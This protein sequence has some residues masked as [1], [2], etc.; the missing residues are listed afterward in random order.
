MQGNLRFQRLVDKIQ[1]PIQT[2]PMC[3]P[4]F[5]RWFLVCIGLVTA[6]LT[7]AALAGAGGGLAANEVKNALRPYM[8]AMHEC[9][10]RQ[11]E[12]NPS[13]G[14]KLELSFTIGNRGRIAR[15]ELLTEE[16][17]ESYIA[18]C[19]DGVLRSV[20]FPRFKGQP[21]VVPKFPIVLGTGADVPNAMDEDDQEK[22]TP[23][24][25]APRKIR[26]K[27]L[28]RLKTAVAGLRACVR[29]HQE[30][31]QK[32]PPRKR[33][34]RNRPIGPL[35]ISFILN[36]F[37]RTTEVRVLD[38]VHGKNHVAGCVAGVLSFVEF[39]MQGSDK[40]SFSKVRL[41]RL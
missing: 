30:K 13:L 39:P 38:K 34:R 5:R 6:L 37:G 31:I 17:A 26:A 18:G 9:A 4:V 41:P 32:R 15:I 11:H 36:Q 27:V 40:L 24:R 19:A 35:K 1:P 21:V 7:P 25:E 33:K 20:V 29:D 16:H 28:R 2:L 3:R 12:M 10:S 8:Q 22:P 23:V 14:G